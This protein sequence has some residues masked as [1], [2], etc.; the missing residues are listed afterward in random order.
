MDVTLPD[1]AAIW[2]LAFLGV[3]GLMFWWIV[4]DPVKLRPSVYDV[5]IRR[6][7]GTPAPADGEA[8]D[9][10]PVDAAAENDA[11]PKRGFTLVELLVTLAIVAVLAS[12]ALP[13]AELASRRA[14]EQELH[15]ALREIRGA[16]DAWHRAVDEGRI[17]QPPAL[18]GYPPSLRALVDGAPD[19]ASGQPQARLYFLRRIP[20]DPFCR[21]PALPDDATWGKRDYRSSAAHPREGANVYDVYSKADGF[22]LNGIPY[23][24]W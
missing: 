19:A 17:V 12:A 13:V 20:R 10:P 6:K 7:R 15:Q 14:K 21:D 22:G 3:A 8:Q 11:A 23:R 18:A 24:K 5:P 16:L 4:V 2:L 9:E 1:H